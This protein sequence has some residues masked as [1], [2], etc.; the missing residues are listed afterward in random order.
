MTPAQLATLKAA[1][2]ADPILNAQPLTSDGAFFIAAELNKQAVPDFFVWR[3][4]L[5]T[6]EI[7]GNGFLW[8]RVKTMTVD[9][10]RV[11]RYMTGLSV[12]DPSRANVRDGIN[13]AFSGAGDIAM[14]L[15]VF[16][17]CQRLA[18]RFEKMFGVG[19]G[20]TTTNA[21]VGP[22]TM[23][24]QGPLVYQDVEAARSLP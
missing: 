22:A 16:G 17:H 1:I 2:L 20:V 15:A 3:S 6:D 7:M 11:W 10:D 23:G 18:T 5:T 8:S 24:L 12:I 14:R 9:E 19:T 4:Q 21:G 13:S